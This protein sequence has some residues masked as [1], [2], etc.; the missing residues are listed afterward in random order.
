M[1][2]LA[3]FISPHLDDA[4]FS[5]AGAIQRELAV[6]NRAVIATLFSHGSREHA[7][8]RSEDRAAAAML[9]AEPVHLGLRDAPWR[10][11][12]YQG[13]REIVLGAAP[14]DSAEPVVAALTRCIESQRPSVIYAPLAVGTHI[15]HRLAFEAARAVTAGTP[16]WFYEDRPYVLADGAAELRLQGLGIRAG[17]FDRSAF[18]ATFRRLPHVRRYLPAGAERRVCEAAMLAACRDRAVGQARARSFPLSPD[19]ARLARAAAAAHAS[20]W[21]DFAGSERAWRRREARH[22]ARLGYRA[23][24]AERYWSLP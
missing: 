5:C 13:F 24:R 10:H 12:Y 20:Q 17:E 11:R 8:R 23:P 14:G 9:G 7:T 4:V 1:R 19:E 6:G 2:K 21:K 3:L 15:D 18:L 22:A 16:T